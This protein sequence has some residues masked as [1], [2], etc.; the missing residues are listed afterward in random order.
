MRDLVIEPITAEAFAPFGLLVP[1]VR[2]GE[3]RVELIEQLQ[4]LRAQARPRLSLVAVPA[5][6]LPLEAVEMERH[7]HSSQTFIPIAAESYLLLVAPHGGEGYPDTARLR[8]FRVPG[9]VGIH[10][11]ADVWHHPMTALDG[12]ARFVVTTF[13]D[14]T[15][16]DEEFIPLREIVRIVA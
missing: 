1:P 6:S 15:K 7:I 16:D 14:S 4:N 11:N 9:D 8:A 10:Y 12:P 5:T 3:R 13:I 2:S